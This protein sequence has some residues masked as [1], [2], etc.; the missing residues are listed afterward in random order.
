VVAYDTGVRSISCA[1]AV[2]A[3][4]DCAG[5]TAR[6]EKESSPMAKPLNG[7]LLPDPPLAGFTYPLVGSIRGAVVVDPNGTHLE[8]NSTSTK[9]PWDQNYRV[10]TTLNAESVP[11]V[12]HCQVHPLGYEP[13]TE[14]VFGGASPLAAG[15]IALYDDARARWGELAYDRD[16]IRVLDPDGKTRVEIVRVQSGA[17]RIKEGF[18]L[19][20][21]GPA[22]F[23]VRV[24]S[25]DGA[26]VKPGT[27][28]QP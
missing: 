12:L 10:Q 2:L 13:A 9:N 6:Q 15:R 5:T 25:A 1:L 8:I 7:D 28:L 18:T 19:P 17:P 16:A 22:L 21:I 11:P 14:I 3:L 24:V 26:P 20:A 4:L 23:H 27:L